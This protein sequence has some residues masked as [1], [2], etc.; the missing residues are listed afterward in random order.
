MKRI[1]KNP[2]PQE[3]LDWKALE[4]EEWKPTYGGLQNPEKENLH[5][6]LLTEQGEICCYCNRRIELNDSHIEH[7]RPQNY[8]GKLYN[9]LALD[10]QNLLSSCQRDGKKGE[11]RHCGVLKADWFEEPSFI[12]PLEADCES[13][14]GFTVDGQIF[15]TNEQDKASI[16]TISRLGLK[17]DK[18]KAG[19]N[20][21]IEGFL[22]PDLTAK[23]VAQLI[24]G[25]SS[26][27]SN[28][29]FHEFCTALLYVLKSNY[30]PTAT[31]GKLTTDERR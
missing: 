11:P 2:E 15:P 6:A 22:L 9:H 29:R 31:R 26:R 3:F 16:E 25:L 1:I 4:N 5:K 30:W 13:K 19:R 20:R 7:L 24:S 27:D 10:Y 12:S 21:A 18:L 8:P 28:N 14:F 23:E 17:I